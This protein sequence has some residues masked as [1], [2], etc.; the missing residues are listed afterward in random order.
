M[1]LFVYGTLK[2][3]E[4]NHRLMA[5]QHFVRPA[6]TEPGFRLIDLGPYPGMVRAADRPGVWGELY[7]VSECGVDELDDFEG[8]P[9]LFVR[10][11]IDLADGERAWA[12][13]YNRPVPPHAATG[14]R[15]PL[16]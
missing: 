13:L 4:R 8:V 15:W 12:Y 7:D 9:E 14:D 10:E 5:G 16:G 1:R 6:Q 11:V 3:G 2:R